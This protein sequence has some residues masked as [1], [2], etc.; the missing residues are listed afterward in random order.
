MRGAAGTAP[1]SAPSGYFKL[2][3]IYGCRPPPVCHGV[4]TQAAQLDP[5]SQICAQL[6]CND[7]GSSQAPET[8]DMPQHFCVRI[9]KAVVISPTLAHLT[10]LQ[11]LRLTCV[12]ND[13]VGCRQIRNHDKHLGIISQLT[14]LTGLSLT[15]M[16][17]NVPA[18]VASLSRLQHLHLGE[19]YPHQHRVIAT[20]LSFP[21]SLALCSELHHLT[22]TSLSM[23]SLKGWWGIC[24]S[25]ILL[26][27]LS[28]L[29][30]QDTHLELVGLGDWVL[31]SH[32]TSLCL[33]DC[34]LRKVPAA[35]CQLPNLQHLTMR[36]L[37]L[38]SLDDGPYLSSLRSMMISCNEESQGSEALRSAVHMAC[39]TVCFKDED[40]SLK[41]CFAQAHLQTILP[42][43]CA[44]CISKRVADC[45]KPKIGAVYVDQHAH[46]YPTYTDSDADDHESSDGF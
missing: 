42:T 6:E 8:A 25:L 38:T 24:R 46:A 2:R 36:G 27:G 20:S 9:V 16:V 31:S 37:I 11:E 35:A 21:A 14:N 18:E 23:A 17:Q 40:Q 39:L 22:L 19:S 28:S 29:T 3:D 13:P 26:P 30:I 34:G 12:P 44:I 41:G 4:S 5:S 7:P 15:C 32:L 1:E 45:D 33:I 43:T 10:Q